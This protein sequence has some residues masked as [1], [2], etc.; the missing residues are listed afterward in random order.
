MAVSEKM[1]DLE[2][3]RGIAVLF[4]MVHHIQN[5]LV[6]WNPPRL[7]EFFRYFGGSVGVDLFFVISGF[8]IAKIYLAS[9]QVADR[10][11]A[12]GNFLLFWY[13]RAIR[14]LPAA[15]FWL[16][17]SVVLN[18]VFNRSGAFGT[19][20]ATVDGA[21]A[22]VLNIANM[23]FMDCFTVYECGPNAIHWTL[24]LEQQFYLVF[25]FV[26][27]LLGKRLLPVLAVVIFAQFFSETLSTWYGF[28]ITGFCLGICLAM[29]SNS[30]VHRVLEPTPLLRS[31][32]LHWVVPLLLLALLGNILSTSTRMAPPGVRF[33]IAALVGAMLVLLAS[34]DKNYLLPD[35]PLKRLLVWVGSRSYSLYLCHILCY[36]ATREFF[37]RVAPDLARTTE[38]TYAYLATGIVLAFVSAELSYRFIE[39]T[40]KD[41]GSR[42]VAAI[43]ARLALRHA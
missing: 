16:A 24:S 31:R 2:F 37:F 26:A 29:L 21:L 34:Y 33:D 35:S 10:Q 4:V 1:K 30:W 22:A 9:F 6:F 11:D 14:L 19:L 32:V 8:I 28:R 42:K 20:Q 27:Y 18:L 36:A 40:F 15:W 7:M 43:K 23:R 5:D 3:L 38:G 17:L 12:T 39:V 41:K 13:R 25:P